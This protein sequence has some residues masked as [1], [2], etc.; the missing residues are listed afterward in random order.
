MK[1]LIGVPFGFALL[2]SAAAE[3]PC[4]KAGEPKINGRLRDVRCKSGIP[5]AAIVIKGGK[6]KRKGKSDSAGNFAVCVPV[7]IY[8]VTVEK[9]GYKRYIVNDLN[10]TAEGNAIVDL[11]MEHGWATDDPNEGKTE[12]CPAAEKALQQSLSVPISYTKTPLLRSE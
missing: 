11:E 8:Q 1:C 10:V 4:P 3:Q 9:Y 6:L 5:K 12:P 2:V 7:G